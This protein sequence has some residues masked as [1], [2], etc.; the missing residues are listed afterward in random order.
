MNRSR[1]VGLSS[2]PAWYCTVIGLFFAVRAVTTLAGGASFDAP[3]T[4]WRATFQLG[5]VA[6]LAVGVFR[7]RST[8]PCVGIVAAVYT[9]ATIA[10]AFHG[11]DLFGVIP[12]D[13]R[14]RFVHPLIVVLAAVSLLIARHGPATASDVPDERTNEQIADPH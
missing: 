11:S 4:G 3:G 10:E 1:W 6:V 14:D 7:E 2:V 5:A 9:I 12:V 8:R 13:Q